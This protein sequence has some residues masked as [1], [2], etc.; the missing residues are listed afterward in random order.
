MTTAECF[1]SFLNAIKIDNYNQIE[2]R[3]HEITKKLNKT[4]RNTDSDTANCL[5]VGS[6]GRYT[7]IKGISDLDMLYIMPCSLWE[8]Y[9]NSP[10]SLL[11]DVKDA[12][13]N[14]YPNTKIK[15]DRLVVDVIFSNFT[16]EIQP[17]FEQ[18]DGNDIYYKYPDTYKG[19][20][21]KITKPKHEQKAMTDFNQQYGQAHRHLC[22]MVRAWKNNVGQNMGGLLVD[23]LTHRFLSSNTE[24]AQYSFS[25]YDLLCRDF[26]EYLKEEPEQTHYQ[27][28]GSR[29]DVK[30]KKKFQKKAS[31]AYSKAVEAIAETDEKKR[32]DLWREIFGRFFPAC[33]TSASESI[34][35]SAAYNDPEQFIE[36]LYP[37]DIRYNLTIDCEIQRNGFREIMLSTLLSQHR[38]ISRVRSLLFQIV[39]TDV[40]MP[41]EVKWKV[42][43]VGEIARQRNC[44]R[45]EIYDSN[46]DGN[47]RRESSDFF[48]PHYV[49]CYIIQHG[50]VVA[51]D[52]IDVPIDY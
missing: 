30:V 51:R 11:K 12:L 52:R 37:I 49:E 20:C 29:Q 35:S 18:K 5:Q 43:N 34:S 44:L 39:N 4:F 32:H 25:K 48:G 17:V 28:L 41:Y 27:A 6:Y 21:Y 9:K 26:F 1:S 45:G 16:F 36:D 38:R 10:S 15:V 2:N 50:V 33:T 47:K 19:G 8:E 31:K 14:R 22:K 40:P 23:T 42:R 3:Y 46:R 7:G 24:L 13:V